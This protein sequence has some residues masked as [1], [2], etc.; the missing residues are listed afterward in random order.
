MTNSLAAPIIEFV[1][2]VVNKSGRQRVIV[3]VSGGLD[4]SVVLSLLVQLLPKEVITP[5]FLPYQ[6]QDMTD[7]RFL[8]EWLGIAS[9]QCVEINIQPAVE[10]LAN[11]A[12]QTSSGGVEKGSQ[13]VFST[14]TR[15]GNIMARTRM[16]LL[17]DLAAAHQALVVGTENR[18]E[19][20]LGYFTRYGDAASD[21]EPL[22]HLY[23]TQVW[24]LGRELGLPERFLLKPPSAGLW[25]GQTDETEMGFSYQQADAI[26]MELEQLAEQLHRPL[27]ELLHEELAKLEATVTETDQPP[28][29]KM[30]VLNRIKQN[31]FKQ[32][33]S[34]KMS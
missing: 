7:A 21:L 17:F 12:F 22:A 2:Q 19:N 6:D 14:Q 15:L 16:I 13:S 18:S 3:G 28:N 9:P 27:I 20:L 30:K 1:R 29:I 8:C 31:W 4:S 33:V 26:L 32:E 25:A 23:K 10:Q 24:Q 11:L 34:Y 5:V